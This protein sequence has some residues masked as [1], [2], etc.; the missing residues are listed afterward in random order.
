[1][2]SIHT[3][4]YEINVRQ[5]ATLVSLA[6]CTTLFCSVLEAVEFLHVHA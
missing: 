2:Q 6:A 3:G 1:M 4:V 5:S